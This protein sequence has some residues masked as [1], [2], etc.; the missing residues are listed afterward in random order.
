MTPS[1][2][3]N[4]MSSHADDAQY[5]RASKASVECQLPV[6]APARLRE[7]ASA[8]QCIEG[9]GD[10]V[11]LAA[12]AVSLCHAVANMKTD[13]HVRHAMVA[14]T[15]AGI[16]RR[17]EARAV[18]NMTVGERDVYRAWRNGTYSPPQV[19]EWGSV[20]TADC[21]Q[22][23]GAMRF[24]AAPE[25]LAALY[26]T[27]GLC[28]SHLAAWL[29]DPSKSTPHAREA[30]R[31]LARVRRVRTRIAKMRTKRCGSRAASKAAMAERSTL[32]RKDVH[33]LNSV[34]GLVCR[35]E[36]AVLGQAHRVLDAISEVRALVRHM[37]KDAR[38]KSRIRSR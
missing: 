36:S 17:G 1:A 34:L 28:L 11:Q 27:S 33:V 9:T 29:G 23:R 5:S 16:A 24:P 4:T 3:E 13:Y 35:K 20:M 38:S 14:E 18:E 10:L 31:A 21:D 7:V 8:A 6:R 26:E 19:P 2:G 37:M 32:R 25:D 15:D 22:R 30:L 12:G